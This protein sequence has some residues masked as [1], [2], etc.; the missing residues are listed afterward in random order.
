MPDALL[1]SQQYGKRHGKIARA[2]RARVRTC[3]AEAGNVAERQHDGGFEVS[4]FY[5][6]EPFSIVG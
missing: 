6:R 2:S 5:F 3:R 4:K 1:C